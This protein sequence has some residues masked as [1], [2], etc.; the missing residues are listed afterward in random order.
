[1]PAAG[2]FNP[3]G[4]L[5]AEYR[6][7]AAGD[8]LAAISLESGSAGHDVLVVSGASS[9]ML[10]LACLSDLGRGCQIAGGLRPADYPAYLFM[11]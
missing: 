1:M 9:Q 2:V 5:N 10:S 6:N 7:R 3:I 11:Q 4:K 8:G